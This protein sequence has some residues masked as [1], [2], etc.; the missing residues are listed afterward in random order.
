MVSMIT[1]LIVAVIALAVGVTAGFLTR[2]LIAE[3]QIS[4][5]KRYAQQIIESAQKEAAS[6][7]KEAEIEA[8]E[9]FLKAQTEFDAKTREAKTELANLE[10]RARQ[11]EELLDKKLESLDRKEKELS[12]KQAELNASVEKLNTQKAE[13]ETIISE[14]RRKLENISG[15]SAEGAKQELMRSMLDEAKQASLLMIKRMEE[16]AKETAEKKA[17]D[18]VTTAI[19]RVAADQTSEVSVSVVALPSDDMKGRIIG[20][21]GRNIKT[22]ETMTGVDFIIDDT[23]EA[24]TIS[25]FDPVRRETAKLALQKLIQDGRIHPGRIEEVV[26]KTKLEMEQKIKELGEQAAMD[27]GITNLHPEII[28]LLGKL[29]YRTSYGQNVLKHSVEMAYI[30]SMMASELGIDPTIAKR[31][32]LL[33]DIGKAIDHEVQG[34]HVALGVEAAKKYGESEAILHAIEAHH[35]DKEPKSIE[36]VLV[37]AADAISAARP[38][39]RRET[40]ENYVK[41]LENLEKIANSFEGIQRSFAIQAGREIRVMVETDKV[42]DMKSFALSKDI[43]KKIEEELEYPG[44][45]RVTVIRELRAVEYAK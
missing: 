44:M 30:C 31:A 27:V 19:Q 29:H 14:Q 40:L 15:L 8:K 38:G 36:A 41:R 10:K 12:T 25:A 42:D 28:K 20:R 34:S 13:L 33:H 21:E 35:N 32:A 9:Q 16:E 1:T 4:G 22:L 7:K 5:A 3:Q 45:I 17:R 23:P 18:I 2:K 39:A 26:E 37:Q 43:A 24:V 11:R 6:I